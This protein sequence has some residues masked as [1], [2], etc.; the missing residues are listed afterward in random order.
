MP[1]TP[2]ART[3]TEDVAFLRQHTEAIV[4]E[5]D[6]GKVVVAPAYQ[7][8]VMTS[9][10]GDADDMSFGWLND[11]VIAAGIQPPEMVKG[12]L[13][14][15]IYVFGGEERFWLG[16][17]GGQFAIY[18]EKGEPFDFTHW[19]TPAV[20][21]SEPF[22]LV[23]H[24]AS[25]AQFVRNFTL[26][27]YSGY[28]FDGRIQRRVT[29]LGR[30]ETEKALKS[31]LPP[32]VLAV[33]YR[34][35]NVLKNTGPYRWSRDTGLLS[36]WLLGMYKPG[37]TTT[38][39]IPFK[40]GSEAALGPVVNDAY[41]GRVPA[42]RLIVTDQ[43]LYFSA[44]G[45]YRSKIGLTAKRSKGIAGSYDADGRVLTVVAYNQQPAAAPYVNSMWALQ[46]APYAG[47]VINAYNDGAPE[48]G[49]KPLGPFYEIET[50]SPGAELE[51]GE[52]VTH[53]QTT[54]HLRGPEAELDA[55][56]RR[57]FGVSLETI[58][59]ALP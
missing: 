29:V 24:S 27:N 12:T 25:D 17:E 20:I 58:K 49:T 6:G 9:S 35:R 4:L 15:H 18:F 1:P 8:R 54:A 3:F 2:K 16:P 13:K 55:L 56:A 41:F 28:T 40:R 39:V 42:E 37:A 32:S 47:D 10:V 45:T 23:R 31:H 48:P 14:E 33:A 7:G 46:D 36:I 57:L 22:E 53:V 11:D 50:S 21:D 26:T 30:A 19:N 44:D 38:V 59:T 52:S 5:R 43:A 34:T 51:A